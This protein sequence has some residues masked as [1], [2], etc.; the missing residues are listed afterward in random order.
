[1]HAGERTG[2]PCDAVGYDG[3]AESGKAGGVPIGIDD[4]LGDLRP[5]AVDDP[6]EDCLAGE[7]PQALVSP[8]HAA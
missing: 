6:G 5:K 3:K 8:T 1:M 2:E 4:E 7:R